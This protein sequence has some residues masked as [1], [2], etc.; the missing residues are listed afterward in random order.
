MSSQR[1]T[2]R[3]T[4]IRC[5]PLGAWCFVV[6]PRVVGA[7]GGATSTRGARHPKLS[8]PSGTCVRSAARSPPSCGCSLSPTL[9]SS[10]CT[11]SSFFPHSPPRHP[12]PYL[13]GVRL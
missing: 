8:P 3:E 7:R 11:C 4:V 12:P 9:V 2:S 13:P 10:P 1:L 5:V 6:A